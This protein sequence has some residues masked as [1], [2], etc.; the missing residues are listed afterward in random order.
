MRHAIFV[1]VAAALVLA[2]GGLIYSA[3]NATIPAAIGVEIALEYSDPHCIGCA[4]ATYTV[5]RDRVEL[6][7]AGACVE[8]GA[9]AKEIPAEAFDR[10]VH[11]IRASNVFGR[12]DP[13][14]YCADCALRTFRFRDGSHVIV[15][16]AAGPLDPVLAQLEAEILQLAGPLSRFVGPRQ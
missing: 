11:R 4:E 10:V 3:Q 9:H 13:A 14:T 8:P 16:Q 5:S 15:R 1:T 2:T 6:I 7:C 12:P